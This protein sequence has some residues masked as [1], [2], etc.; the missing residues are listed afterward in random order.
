MKKGLTSLLLLS[1]FLLNNAVYA[2]IPVTVQ[3]SDQ[4]QQVAGLD[5]DS[6]AYLTNMGI[7]LD[8]MNKIPADDL[9]RYVNQ[10]KANGFSSAQLQKFIKATICYQSQPQPQDTMLTGT[11]NSKG[12][13]V[14]IGGQIIQDPLK[15][16]HTRVSASSGT[17]SPA[18]SGGI[19]T[20][21]DPNDQT[22]VYYSVQSN[23]GY[24]EATAKL[25]LP[26]INANLSGV[27]YPYFI[28]SVMNSAG[29]VLGDYGLRYY[30]GV[31]QKYAFA[32]WWDSSSGTY[33]W[34]MVYGKLS[35]V[36]AAVYLDVYANYT[37][38]N[39]YLIVRNYSNWNI[40]SKSSLEF[41]SGSFNSSFS[42]IYL[43]R[44]ITMAQVHASGTPLNSN[45]GSHFSN[46]AFSLGSIYSPSGYW[47]WGTSQT[48]SAYRAAP[49]TRQLATVAVNSHSAWYA[50]NVS[51]WFNVP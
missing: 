27:D 28:I 20:R 1:L 31:W 49:T 21:V 15:G 3:N 36:P 47:S 22:G 23:L 38:Q 25:T 6:Q 39:V 35:V 41:P 2:A 34:S 26:T 7:S 30:N 51:I 8:D 10:S 17:I 29:T 37:D 45:T 43:V 18:Y 14:T 11:V 24:S 13:L 48:Y 46:A 40:I 42:D 12:D 32:K 5:K 33:Q 50:E 4:S 16:L 9:I 19:G 44:S